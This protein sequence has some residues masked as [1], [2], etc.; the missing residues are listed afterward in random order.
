MVLED[1]GGFWKWAHVFLM[2]GLGLTC[3]ACTGGLVFS[4]PQSLREDGFCHQRAAVRAWED[5]LGVNV[6]CL[7]KSMHQIYHTSKC[8]CLLGVSCN[9]V[10]IITPV[11]ISYTLLSVKLNLLS[12]LQKNGHLR[13]QSVSNFT[14]SRQV[15]FF[16]REGTIKSIHGSQKWW[17]SIH[18]V[19]RHMRLDKEHAVWDGRIDWPAQQPPRQQCLD[20]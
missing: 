5:C 20:N 19:R 13:P 17:N 18:T 12:S 14:E 3:F 1:L 15:F 16:L 10:S 8:V 9:V 7:C 2:G 4:S 11:Q 6:I